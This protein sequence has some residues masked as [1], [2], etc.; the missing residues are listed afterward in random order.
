MS[1]KHYSEL[2]VRSWNSGVVVARRFAFSRAAKSLVQ[3]YVVKLKDG[4][5][6]TMYESEMTPKPL[7]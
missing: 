5:A 7:M 1:A 4:L 3:A 6:R 2:R